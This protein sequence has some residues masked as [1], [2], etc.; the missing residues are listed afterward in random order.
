MYKSQHFIRKMGGKLMGDVLVFG[1]VWTFETWKHTT[2]H[3][4]LHYIG[5]T[6]AAERYSLDMVCAH[7]IR[8][9]N[10]WAELQQLEVLARSWLCTETQ[11]SRRRTK[12]T[13]QAENTMCKSNKT[14]GICTGVQ[15]A[16]AVKI[17][18][19]GASGCAVLQVDLIRPCFS[20]GVTSSES[21]KLAVPAGRLSGG[22]V[23]RCCGVP[24][25]Q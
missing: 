21:P 14:G 20:P 7:N 18:R 23:L 12:L 17:S 25:T 24:R 22:H 8:V 3:M 6:I 19:C 5:R 4:R 1:A 13:D 11:R 10:T 9:C 16:V 2:K 15:T